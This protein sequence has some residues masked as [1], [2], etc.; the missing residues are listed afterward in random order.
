[1]AAHP[2]SGVGL[3]QRH[4]VVLVGD[5]GRCLGSARVLRTDGPIFEVA[6]D[7]HVSSDLLDYVYHG[8]H[9]RITME[10]DGV[11][12]PGMLVTGWSGR[13]RWFIRLHP[14]HSAAG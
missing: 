2:H 11:R 12:L 4:D 6:V 9:R 7:R 8:G 10:A 1:M 3:R 13:R 5:H 14:P